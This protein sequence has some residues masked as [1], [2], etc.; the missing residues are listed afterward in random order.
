MRIEKTPLIMMSRGVETP[1]LFRREGPWRNPSLAAAKR[2]ARLGSRSV[3]DSQLWQDIVAHHCAA[4]W[5]AP[6]SPPSLGPSDRRD[7]ISS[8]CVQVRS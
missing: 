6:A 8:G 7:L 4:S 2:I 3:A 5:R 1:G